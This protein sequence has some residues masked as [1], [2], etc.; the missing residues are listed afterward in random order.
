ML[1]TYQ[2]SIQNHNSLM[3]DN[4]YMTNHARHYDWFLCD[5]LARFL[6]V[7]QSYDPSQVNTVTACYYDKPNKHVYIACN[8]NTNNIMRRINCVR[9]YLSGKEKNILACIQH[10]YASFGSNV[11]ADN[12]YDLP[13]TSEYKLVITHMMI[14]IKLFPFMEVEFEIIPRING[15]HAEMQ[16]LSKII[17]PDYI[18]VS[19]LCCPLCSLMLEQSHVRFYG[20]KINLCASRYWQMP[21]GLDWLEETKEK[22]EMFILQAGHLADAEKQT[23]PIYSD[24]PMLH[25]LDRLFDDL[26]LTP[27]EHKMLARMKN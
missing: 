27:D 23:Y 5:V 4:I 6:N 13:L 8:R 22:I 17:N 26:S 21:P 10:K 11:N 14:A 16:I 20:K 7:K 1:E 9:D 18:G 2:K 12:F 25:Y 24:E 15:V 3:L 19:A